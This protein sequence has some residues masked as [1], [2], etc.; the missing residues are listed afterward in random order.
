M[1]SGF[2]GKRG[3]YSLFFVLFVFAVFLLMRDDRLAWRD[4]TSKQAVIIDDGLAY[5]V[6]FS[7]AK[8]IGELLATVGVPM[9][10]QDD[11]FP[12][13]DTKALPGM[14]VFV[15]RAKA[16]SATVD[17]GTKEWRTLSKTVEEAIADAGI[18][19]D[20]DDIVKP[21]REE[22]VHAGTKI[23]IVRVEVREESVEKAVA[24]DKKANEDDKLSWR[25]TIV[26]QKGEKGIDRLTYRVS[27]HDGKEV[28][29]KLIKTERIKDPVTEITTQGTYVK[30]GKAHTGA[31]SWYAF[32][33]TMAAANPWLPMGSYVRVTNVDNGKSVIVKI[34]DRG[35]F[36][37][38]RIIDLDK[39]AFQKIASTGAG[40]INVKMEEITN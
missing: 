15:R 1:K 33:G 2:F 28:N 17:G 29:R 9:G 6:S 22:A 21:A 4:D 3:M 12:S 38:G 23:S 39:V 10:E 25:K 18:T 14:T 8:T 13:Q 35:P 27:S 24:F 20:E 11:V 7:G 31:A 32:T 19:L 40:V 34:N 16:V 36:V 37:P 5:Q 26:T 30:V